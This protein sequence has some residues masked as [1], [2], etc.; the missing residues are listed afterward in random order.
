MSMNEGA[1]VGQLGSL[2][3]GL[4]RAEAAFDELRICNVPRYDR[5]F[6][7]RRSGDAQA[8][9]HFPFEN[10]L[11]GHCRLDGAE[12]TVAATVGASAQ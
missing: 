7:P 3:S 11:T 1:Y 4:R 6:S 9:L 8:L 12:A 5:D 2:N 10:D